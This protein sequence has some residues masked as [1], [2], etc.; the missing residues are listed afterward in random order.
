MMVAG[1]MVGR[2]GPLHLLQMV[3]GLMAGSLHPENL[4]EIR[5]G[6]LHMAVV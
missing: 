4:Q 1:L 5:L 3:V 6:R 2:I